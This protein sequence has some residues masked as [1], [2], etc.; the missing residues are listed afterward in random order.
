MHRGEFPAVPLLSQWLCLCWLCRAL[1]CPSLPAISLTMSGLGTRQAGSVTSGFRQM[2]GL[3]G[4]GS[5]MW[6]GLGSPAHQL[7]E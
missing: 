1:T 5:G 7:Y 4:S 3:H 2:G 6:P